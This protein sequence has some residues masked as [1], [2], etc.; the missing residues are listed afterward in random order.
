MCVCTECVEE[1]KFEACPLCKQKIKLILNHN[2]K[3]HQE[4]EDWL[5]EFPYYIPEKFIKSF[6]KN[7]QKAINRAICQAKGEDYFDEDSLSPLGRI[8]RK[9]IPS[10]FRLS[11]GQKN[12][13]LTDCDTHPGGSAFQKDAL[14]DAGAMTPRASN[15]TIKYSRDSVVSK[16]SSSYH[17]P[18][19]DRGRIPIQSDVGIAKVASGGGHGHS[20][21]ARNNNYSY[22]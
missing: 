10:K 18:R 14:A 20:R 6:K 3:E 1:R 16:P 5:Y 21:N 4:Y 7:S 17:S 9:L 22:L 12:K 2:G 13:A 15:V 11:I 8:A 19:N